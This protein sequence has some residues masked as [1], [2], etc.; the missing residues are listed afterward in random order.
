MFTVCEGCLEGENTGCTLYICQTKDGFIFISCIVF[1]I[2]LDAYIL[3]RVALDLGGGSDEM[4]D[5]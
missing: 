4:S 2:E 5:L 3:Q 1:A